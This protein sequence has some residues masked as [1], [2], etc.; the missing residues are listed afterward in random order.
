MKMFVMVGVLALSAC[1]AVVK[2]SPGGPTLLFPRPTYTTLEEARASPD[3]Q[4]PNERTVYVQNRDGKYECY[5]WSVID[6]D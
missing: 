6:T 2:E 3:C 1:T 4:F 5:P